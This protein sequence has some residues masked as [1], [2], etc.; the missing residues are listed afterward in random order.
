[1]S[2]LG[3]VYPQQQTSPDT[4]GT[5]LLGQE[6]TSDVHELGNESCEG[7]TRNA[8]AARKI[9]LLQLDRLASGHRR[10]EADFQVESAAKIATMLGFVEHFC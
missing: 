1:M 9:D 4:V 8:K 2:A 5:S 6:L 3:P 10:Y 7:C